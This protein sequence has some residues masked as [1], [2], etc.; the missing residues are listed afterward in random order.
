[1]G[2][3]KRFNILNFIIFDL[4]TCSFNSLLSVPLFRQM[5]DIIKVI[6]SSIKTHSK[7]HCPSQVSAIFSK[8]GFKKSG[9]RGQVDK[10]TAS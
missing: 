5:S 10:A 3:T 6:P 1:M 7:P 8:L 9:T 2:G 4:L